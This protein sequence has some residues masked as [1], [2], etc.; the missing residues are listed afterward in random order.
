VQEMFITIDKNSYAP[1]EVKMRQGSKW[2]RFVISQL[3]VQNLSDSEFVFNSKD[4]PT[5]EVIDLR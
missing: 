4:F 1:T 5:A 3:K 2:T